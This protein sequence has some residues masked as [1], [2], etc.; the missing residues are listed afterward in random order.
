MT[1]PIDLREISLYAEMWKG[2]VI[3]DLLTWC[4]ASIKNMELKQQ[5]LETQVAFWKQSYELATAND[6]DTTPFKG[7]DA[8]TD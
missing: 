1:H 6:L 8:T 3:G 7:R 2:H 4:A 5:Q